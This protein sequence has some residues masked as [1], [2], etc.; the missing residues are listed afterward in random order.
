MRRTKINFRLPSDVSI[1]AMFDT[2]NCQYDL[3]YSHSKQDMDAKP[4]PKGIETEVNWDTKKLAI[5][6]REGSVSYFG[7]DP[8]K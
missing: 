4:K 8:N 6:I 7:I 1:L 2:S 3:G 5:R